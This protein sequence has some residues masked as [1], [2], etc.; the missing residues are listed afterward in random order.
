LALPIYLL[1]RLIGLTVRLKVEGYEKCESL[2]GGKIFAGWHGRTLL[3]ALFFAG[4]GVWTII[5]QSNDGKLQDRVFRR[6][7]FQTIRGS[8][9]R[10]GVRAAIESIKVLRKGVTMAFTPDGPRG[11]THVVQEGIM[12]MAQKS[13]AWIVPVGASASRRRLVG[14][15]DRYMVPCF[16]SRGIMVFGEPMQVPADAD[17]VALENLRQKLEQE[18]NQL[19]EEAERRMGHGQK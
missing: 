16:F 11:P 5:S 8:S 10:G 3:A 19:E 14:T 7:G 2:P 12:L 15:W 9:G 4:K 18:L 1:V 17:S 13:G 6:F